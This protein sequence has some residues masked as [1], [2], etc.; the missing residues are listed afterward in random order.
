MNLL[1][2]YPGNISAIGDCYKLAALRCSERK[3]VVV[4]GYEHNPAR[5]DLA[6][7]IAAFE[8][9]ATQVARFRLSPRVECRRIGLIHPVH[10]CLRVFAWEVM[11]K[12]DS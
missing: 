8:I 11:G 9:V 2:P 3:A 12:M 7:L 5:I 6:P 1:H 4:I 10:E